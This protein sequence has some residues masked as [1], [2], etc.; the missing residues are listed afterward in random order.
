M[1]VIYNAASST[2]RLSASVTSC[3]PHQVGH[4]M[5][6]Q[7]LDNR[8]DV[9]C[10]DIVGVLTRRYAQPFKEGTHARDCGVNAL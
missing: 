4:A 2:Q 6:F 8:I 9:L 7:L 5:R 1:T 3:R 10:D